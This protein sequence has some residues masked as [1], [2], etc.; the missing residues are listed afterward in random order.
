MGWILASFRQKLEVEVSTVTGVI[1]CAYAPS[2]YVRATFQ[3]IQCRNP[4]K[5]SLFFN[6]KIPPRS[7][8]HL[9]FPSYSTITPFCAFAG[10]RGY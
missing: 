4:S 3:P 6:R 10:L 8:P 1:V 2:P 7:S 5:H 9:H